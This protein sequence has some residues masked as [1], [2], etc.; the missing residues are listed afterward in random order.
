MDSASNRLPTTLCRRPERI[1]GRA[2]TALL[3]N[4]PAEKQEAALSGYRVATLVMVVALS[5]AGAALAD[6]A[7]LEVQLPGVWQGELPGEEPGEKIRLILTV[8]RER[9][10]LVA[11]MRSPDQDNVDRIAQSVRLTDR[12]VEIYLVFM[13]AAFDGTMSDDGSEMRGTWKQHEYTAPLAFRR[14]V[15]Q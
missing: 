4:A 2:R 13:T 15:T 6:P 5:C 8:V 11:R 14:A 12:R 7:P 1:G 3:H 9:G 10:I